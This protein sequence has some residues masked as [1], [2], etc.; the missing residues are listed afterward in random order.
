MQADLSVIHVI[1]NEVDKLRDKYRKDYNNTQL[2]TEIQHLNNQLDIWYRRFGY[3][4]LLF[5]GKIGP[6]QDDGFGDI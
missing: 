3:S 6:L 1:R 4:F 2:R 5:V